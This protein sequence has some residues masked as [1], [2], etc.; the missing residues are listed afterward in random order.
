MDKVTGLT[1]R[2][3]RV[4]ADI[5][6]NPSMRAEFALFLRELEAE[7]A[8]TLANECGHTAEGGFTCTRENAHPGAHR[9][10]QGEWWP[11]AFE[12]THRIH[13]PFTGWMS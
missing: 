6:R 9:T 10:E 2:I 4:H 8:I 1:K 13:A 5:K 12:G 3:D 11:Y 7:L